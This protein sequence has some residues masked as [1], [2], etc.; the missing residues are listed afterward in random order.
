MFHNK[1][2]D[3]KNPKV[4]RIVIFN[5]NAISEIVVS[6]LKYFSHYWW[7]KSNRSIIKDRWGNLF[8]N[9]P[10][11]SINIVVFPTNI[12]SQ[13]Y[14]FIDHFEINNKSLNKQWCSV[15]LHSDPYS[16]LVLRHDQWCS[17][18]DPLLCQCSVWDLLFPCSRSAGQRFTRCRLLSAYLVANDLFFSP[19]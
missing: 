10:E 1:F 3:F 15:M 14:L 19:K 7:W 11:S 13:L 18:C 17:W 4:L 16:F 5:L 2:T 9:E 6:G 12:Y 8:R